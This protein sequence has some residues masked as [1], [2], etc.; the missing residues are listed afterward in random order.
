LDDDDIGHNERLIAK[1]LTSW[2]GAAPLVATKGGCTRPGGGW[3]HDGR[4]EHLR[5]A[6]EASLRALGAPRIDLYQLHAPDDAVLLEDSVG[7][8]GRLADQGKIAHVGLSNVNLDELERARRISAIAS[9]QNRASPFAPQG[10]TDGVLARCAAEDIA[11]I[12]YSPVGGYQADRTAHEAALLEIGR[13]LE[14]TPF[15]VALAWLLAQSP[16]LIPIPG[17]S[18]PDNAR[19]SGRAASLDLGPSHLA[20]M[21]GAYGVM[22]RARPPTS[23]S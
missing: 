5:A 3:A 16:A 18:R 11:F 21:N 8:L 22:G 6:C 20:R 23:A 17:A 4:P 10:L 13:E 1:A 14:A 19:S 15:E 9:V 12:A 7:E 2:S